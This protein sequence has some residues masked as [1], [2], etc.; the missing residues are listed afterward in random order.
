MH[1]HGNGG[2]PFRLPDPGSLEYAAQR[3]ILLELVVDPHA[4]GDRFE[5]LCDTLG[6]AD[7][8]AHEAVAALAAA[9]LAKRHANVVV[10]ST[11]AQCFEHLWPIKT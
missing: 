7:V 10:A 11:A 8:D 3:V 6:L 4:G 1:S 2:P 9:G 5:D